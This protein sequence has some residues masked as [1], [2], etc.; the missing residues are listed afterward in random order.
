MT[1]AVENALPDRDRAA[2]WNGV[3]AIT[4]CVFALVASEF[5]PVSLLS[6]VS[7]DLGI[8]EGLA[9]QGIAISG[10]LAVLTSLSISTLAGNIDR[11]ILLLGLT[12]LMAVS[13]VVI[14]L[15]P[16]YLTYMVGRALIGVVIGGFWSMSAAL[17]IRLVPR[18][19][20]PRALAIFNGGNAL[21]MVIAAP[22][23]SY[24]GSVMGWRGAFFCLVPVALV[25]F[26]WQCVSLPSMKTTA[27][28]KKAGNVLRLLRKPQV[29]TGMAAC[30]LFFMGQFALFTYLRPFLETVTR[31]DVSTLSLILLTIGMAGFMGTLII[32]VFLRKGFYL[33][34]MAIPLM[35]TAIAVMLMLT[36]HRLWIVAP[37]LGLWGLVA[38]AAPVGWWS[39]VARTFPDNAEAGGGLMVAVVQLSIALGSTAGGLAF[40]S[41]GWQTTFAISGVLLTLAACLTF[42]TSRTQH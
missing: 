12:T 35:M 15:A 39:W 11:K 5:M 29:A 26:I 8:S 10:A 16:D 42:V 4:L 23:G 1:S 6:P 36:G 31:V 33:T 18:D 9:G 37:L 13:G 22:L 20:V 34:L 41:A 25:V 24:L 30:G 14:A 27:E 2:H 32:G 28:E 3:W 40:D 17:A 19:Q 38:T 21:A 7:R